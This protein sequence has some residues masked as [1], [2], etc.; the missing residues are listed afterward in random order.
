MFL[1]VTISKGKLEL[2]SLW[3]LSVC[4][5]F[6]LSSLDFFAVREKKM[7]AARK[8]DHTEKQRHMI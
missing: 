7:S 3:S 1:W 2:T 6:G 5:F 4:F 8:T